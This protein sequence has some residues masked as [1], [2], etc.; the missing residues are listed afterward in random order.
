MTGLFV[1]THERRLDEPV[2]YDFDDEPRRGPVRL[3]DLRDFAPIIYAAIIAAMLIVFVL[4]FPTL[5]AIQE[6]AVTPRSPL[7]SRSTPR[8]RSSPP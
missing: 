6:N 8:A 3:R 5:N 7:A 4:G 2:I 1:A